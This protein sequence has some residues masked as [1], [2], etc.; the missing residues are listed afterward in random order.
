MRRLGTRSANA[1]AAGAKWLVEDAFH[2]A[3]LLHRAREL[4]DFI[5]T[6]HV[7]RSVSLRLD[8]DDVEA[9]RILVD[10][11]VDAAVTCSADTSARVSARAAVPHRE[12]K[13]DDDLFEEGG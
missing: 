3:S 1:R 13:I 7:P 9:E 2:R 12:K 11:A 5:D 8:V 10:D 6:D 4:S